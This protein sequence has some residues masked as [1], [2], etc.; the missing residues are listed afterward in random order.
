MMKEEMMKTT[1]RIRRLR[2]ALSRGVTLV[3]ILIVLAIVGLIAG[4]IAVYAVPKFQQA[5]RDNTKN[6]LK[7]LHAVAEAWRANHANECPTAQRLKEE[8]ELAASSDI[9]DA[10]GDPYKIQCDD[11]ATIVMS[12]GPDK[13]EGTQDDIK[14]PDTSAAK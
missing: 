1:K 14:F 9:N 3:E 12:W 6:S 8:K 4:G 7:A 2:R 11:D 13:K 10:W 5:Q